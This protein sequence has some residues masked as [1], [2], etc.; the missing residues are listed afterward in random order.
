[1]KIIKSRLELLK[2][3]LNVDSAQPEILVMII[4]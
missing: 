2:N 4:F 3:H 1:M